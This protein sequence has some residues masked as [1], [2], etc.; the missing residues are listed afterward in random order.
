MRHHGHTHS[1][2]MVSPWAD[3]PGNGSV[4]TSVPKWIRDPGPGRKISEKFTNDTS[5][6]T[7]LYKLADKG[8]LLLN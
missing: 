2:E 8:T 3:Q 6:I 1:T 4:G 7:Y 5:K